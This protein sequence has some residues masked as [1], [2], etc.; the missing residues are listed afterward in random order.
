MAVAHRPAG[1]GTASSASS[2]SDEPE[3]LVVSH[4]FDPGV[5]GEPY[6]ATVQLT[7]QRI[8]IDGTPER[9]DRFEH[10]DRIDGVLPGSGPV[11]ITTTVSGLR[12][13]EWDSPW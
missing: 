10:Q 12:A 9:Q 11:S 1:D 3:A 6:T 4:W 5:E 7:G 2:A 13:G 8:G